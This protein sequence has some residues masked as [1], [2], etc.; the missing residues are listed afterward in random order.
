M[1][2]DR[3]VA[4]E[5]WLELYST[6]GKSWLPVL[7]GSMAPLIHPGDE[8]LVSKVA[9][10]QI[11]FGDIIVFRRDGDLIVHRVLKKWRTVDTICFGEK[12]DMSHTYGLVGGEKIVGRVTTVKGRNK[13]LCLSSFLSRLPNLVLSTWLRCTAAG[14]NRLKS[15]RSKTIRGAGRFLYGLSLLLSHI[16]VRICFIIWYPSGLLVR[17]EG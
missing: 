7:T 6:K 13:R 1:S 15:S 17:E 9:V 14:V 3:A 4:N 11:R 5:L 8:V 2:I 12:G 10:E 16:L